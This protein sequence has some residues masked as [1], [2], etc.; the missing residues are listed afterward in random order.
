MVCGP[1][2]CADVVKVKFPDVLEL[3]ELFWDITS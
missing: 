1:L 3:P 2:L